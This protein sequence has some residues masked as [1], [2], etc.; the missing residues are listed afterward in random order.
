MSSFFDPVIQ[1]QKLFNEVSVLLND[2]LQL[3]NAV[4]QEGK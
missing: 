4:R 2:H 3:L 1:F